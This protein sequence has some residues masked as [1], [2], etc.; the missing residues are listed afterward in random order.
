MLAAGRGAGPPLHAAL[1]TS[2]VV[3]TAH[4]R[5][6]NDQYQALLTNSFRW[7]VPTQFN[8]AE[9][10]C[11]RWAIQ[12]PGRAPH[13][14][15]LRRR[16]GHQRGSGPTSRL[17]EAAE[18]VGQRAWCSMGVGQGRPRRRGS[19]GQRPETAVVHMA[20][21]SAWARSSVLP[22]SGLFGPEALEKPRL[23]DSERAASRVVD[24]ASSASSAVRRRDNARTCTRSSASDFADERVLPW[25]SL[26]ARQPSRIQA[27]VTTLLDGSRHPALHLRHH[28]R[29]QGRACCMSRPDR[30]S[31]GLRGL[32][33]TGFPSAATCSGRPRDWAW[34]GGMM[35]ALLPT[36]Y[37][38]HPIVGTRGRFSPGA[39]LRAD[40]ALPG[41]Q[42]DLPVPHRPQKR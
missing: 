36:L 28:R 2:P 4:N 6:M 35:D 12:T 21:Y 3:V 26:L 33:G 42:Y 16:S 17:A 19:G 34:T 23:R 5:A 37:F 15:L 31:A 11:H 40:G 10:C 1:P 8:I 22:G 20:T 13:R 7:L 9:A 30:Q 29:A 32:P 24:A 14:H 41:H 38:G 39:R 18:P 25:R 27:L